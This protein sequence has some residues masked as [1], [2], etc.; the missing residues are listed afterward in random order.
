MNEED[1]TKK[2]YYWLDNGV[3]RP[4]GIYS[5]NNGGD[6]PMHGWYEEKMGVGKVKRSL[7]I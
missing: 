2:K 1:I 7:I 6:Y 4:A 3:K 5:V